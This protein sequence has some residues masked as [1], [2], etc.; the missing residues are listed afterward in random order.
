MKL[1]FMLPLVL[2]YLYCI[3]SQKKTTNIIF[4]CFSKKKIAQRNL[5][6][7]SLKI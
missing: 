7:K 1:S 4:V 3:E 5:F 2:D 6:H